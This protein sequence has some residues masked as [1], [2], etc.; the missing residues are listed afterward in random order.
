M[1]KQSIAILGGAGFL[2]SAIATKCDA[3]GYQVNI[4]TR[5]R[6]NAKHL[7]LLPNVQVVECNLQQLALHLLPILAEISPQA[8]LARLLV[9]S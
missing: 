7:F 6:D 8:L 4:I 2:G 9:S 1:T 3:A 5:R